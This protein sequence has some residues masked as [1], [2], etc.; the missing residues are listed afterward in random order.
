MASSQAYESGSTL[1]LLSDNI[2]N[3]PQQGVAAIQIPSPPLITAHTPSARAS[4]GRPITKPSWLRSARPKPS[5]PAPSS[6]E[7]G[8]NL[9]PTTCTYP[10]RS[11]A[12]EIS[13]PASHNASSSVSVSE[14]AAMDNC[15]PP[16]ERAGKRK[17]EDEALPREKKPRLASSAA[18]AMF[19]DADEGE[20]IMKESERTAAMAKN[21]RVTVASGET[22]ETDN[23][24][25]AKRAALSDD[26]NGVFFYSPMGS[27]RVMCVL[28][29]TVIAHWRSLPCSL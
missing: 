15:S 27:A 23:P 10:A 25:R 8:N 1:Q 18:K 17:A 4:A 2:P 21:R 3:V 9:R 20:R 6:S 22:R 12:P 24:K 13:Q 5:R 29:V 28:Y 14:S 7:L 26:D 19:I 16:T 11:G